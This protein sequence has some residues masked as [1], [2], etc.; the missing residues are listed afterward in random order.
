MLL[1]TWLKTTTQLASDVIHTLCGVYT[2][3]E[4]KLRPSISIGRG[5]LV[6]RQAGRRISYFRILKSASETKIGYSTV[7]AVLF[8]FCN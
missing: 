5:I 4:P 8:S 1:R 6:D 2:T 7:A 3:T